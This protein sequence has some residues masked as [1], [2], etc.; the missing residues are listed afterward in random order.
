[1]LLAE[2]AD[3]SAWDR[4]EYALRAR[5]EMPRVLE[6]SDGEIADP[7][8]GLVAEFGPNLDLAGFLFAGVIRRLRGSQDMLDLVQALN[9]I[10][11]SERNGFIEA[12][13]TIYG[14]HSVFV[15]SGWSRDQLDDRDMGVALQHY[16]QI[17]AIVERWGR[18][19]L[20]IE[21]ACAQSVILDEGLNRADDAIIA[22]D[23]AIDKFGEQPPLLRQKSKAL[24]HAER[25]ADAT[26]LLLRIENTVGVDSPFDRALALRDGGLS[27]ARAKRFADAVRLLDKAEQALRGDQQKKALATGILVEKGLAYWEAG[28][29]SNA[30]LALADALD[31]LETFSLSESRQAERAHQLTRATIGLF[32]HD[33]DPF[34][35]NPRPAISFGHASA[36]AGENEELLNLDLKPLA[37]NWRILA[38]VEAEADLDVGIERRSA[39]KQVSPALASIEHLLCAAR[40]SRAL[41]SLSLIDALR[42]GVTAASVARMA[43]AAIGG[44]RPR[45]RIDRSELFSTT[46]ETLIEEPDWR[47]AILR[48]PLDAILHRST[49]Q[50][51]DPPFL[52]DLRRAC[53]NVFGSDE[54]A[55]SVL[56]AASGLYA[57]GPAAPLAVATA[58]ALA[59]PKEG[60][61]DAPSV[62]FYRD[63]MIIARVAQS[64]ARRLLEPNVVQSIATGWT[65]VLARQRFR[66]RNPDR[67]RPAIEAAI[68]SMSASGLRGAAQLILAAAP[69]VNHDFDVG[70]EELLKRVAG[71]RASD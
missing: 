63:M 26:D 69:A 55:D 41:R 21:L 43:K 30:I 15:H 24:G 7:A 32:M 19:D 13:S 49:V 28:Q 11:A 65:V 36:L 14:G 53:A 2:F 60:V 64:F 6:L 67:H 4:I 50:P 40:Y 27:A 23:T 9:S 68:S 5:A 56:K 42:A 61:A 39:A 58:G 35:S 44:N 71:T 29:R 8:A 33:L 25:H 70:W 34:P 17:E 47:E 52:R 3:V 62:R 57:V 38:I 10:A 37:D 66:L 45:A 18:P 31:A 46:L 48:L 20:M 12:M 59:I 1:V 51:I 16:E 22:V 54:L